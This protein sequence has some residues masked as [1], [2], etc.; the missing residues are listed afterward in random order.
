MHGIF[1]QYLHV[2]ASNS[3]VF[4]F[5]LP[6]NSSSDHLVRLLTSTI[7]LKINEGWR[8]VWDRCISKR[9]RERNIDR[10]EGWR[11]LNLWREQ[12]GEGCDEVGGGWN[13]NRWVEDRLRRMVVGGWWREESWQLVVKVGCRLEV[14]GAV[15][16]FERTKEKEGERVSERGE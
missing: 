11:L 9:E 4:T 5:F 16:G 6:L 10:D 7:G 13:G 15:A 14:G 8:W 1:A 3:R 2:L 12:D